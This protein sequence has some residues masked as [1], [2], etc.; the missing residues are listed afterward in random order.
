MA[1]AKVQSAWLRRTGEA[2]AAGPA[3][4]AGP[5]GA[6]GA[7]GAVGPA[8]PAGPDGAAGAPGS[9][10]LFVHG[11]GDAVFTAGVRT[12]S[13][14]TADTTLTAVSFTTPNTLAVG[15]VLRIRIVG[16]CSTKAAT[17]GTL[18]LT[19]LMQGSS[20]MSIPLTINLPAAITLNGAFAFDAD[21][22]IVAGA[23]NYFAGS[24]YVTLQTISAVI[25]TSGP[26]AVLGF[27][28]DWTFKAKFSVADP[29]NSLTVTSISVEILK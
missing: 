6:A 13:N 27:T 5:A 20:I 22:P 11:Q 21:L 8:G 2:G 4:P 25:N 16:Y 9:V 17:P 12:V 15:N 26:G 24:L 18:T 7:A 14:T 23:V 1:D 29:A 19:L 10:L 28:R 3:G